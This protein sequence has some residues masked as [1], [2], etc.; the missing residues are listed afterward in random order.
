MTRMQRKNKKLTH[1]IKGAEQTLQAMELGAVEQGTEEGAQAMRKKIA[2]LKKTQEA[3]AGFYFGAIGDK[4]ADYGVGL[5]DKGVSSLAEEELQGT[6]EDR[7]GRLDPYAGGI[8]NYLQNAIF[9]KDSWKQLLPQN[10]LFP[11]KAVTAREK[12]QAKIDVMS[13]EEKRQ[14]GIDIGIIPRGPLY[15]AYD[16]KKFESL[17]EDLDYMYPKAKGGRVS[18]LDGGLASLLKK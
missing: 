16:E 6:F 4:K 15:G 10:L 12:E 8:G 1:K 18:Y 7:L 9:T 3:V 13:D 2:D 14:R 5:F 17:Y 11:S